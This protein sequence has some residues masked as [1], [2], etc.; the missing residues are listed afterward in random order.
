VNRA[1]SLSDVVEWDVRNWSTSLDFW[2]ANTTQDISRCSALELG[3]RNGGVS[4]WMAS[5]GAR[6]L[7][8]D[9]EGP[10]EKAIQQHRAHGL[11]HLIE[12]QTLDAT[13]LPY[14]NE[15]DVI[16]FKSVL[17]AVG[18]NGARARQAKAV[19]EMYKALKPGGE[20]FFAENLI[21]SPFHR[22]GR[23][24]FVGWGKT[25][26]YLSVPEIKELFSQFSQLKYHTLG[27]ASTFGRSEIQRNLIGILDE[28]L[29]NK[30]VPES[31]R[32]LIVGVVRK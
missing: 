17:A 4:L 26:A 11:S 19:G 28:K 24:M 27:F 13:N 31:W 15:F 1:I 2:L 16:L 20:L 3:S 30:L 10:T 18:A 6:V 7:C 22:V 14:R 8:S 5:Q 21:A 25:C 32:Y 23:R 29:L 12:Y 9:I